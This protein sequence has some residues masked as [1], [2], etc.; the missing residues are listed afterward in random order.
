V[1][2][3]IGFLLDAA[4]TAFVTSGVDA[5]AKAVSARKRWGTPF[6]EFDG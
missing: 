5:P 6:I 2:R 3:N 4:K 1:Q